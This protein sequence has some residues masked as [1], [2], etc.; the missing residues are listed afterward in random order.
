MKEKLYEWNLKRH[1]RLIKK[2]KPDLYNKWNRDL[3]KEIR[4]DFEKEIEDL[5]T[6]IYTLN[7]ELELTKKEKLK[8]AHKYEGSQEVLDKVLAK[9]EQSNTKKGELKHEVKNLSEDL[10][11]AK[12]VNNEQKE[13]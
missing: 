7:R 10:K 11:E 3:E 9:L 13:Q 1:E 12:E 8:Y 6:D 4:K 5:E 2:W